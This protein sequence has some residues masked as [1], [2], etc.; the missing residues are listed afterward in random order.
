[1]VQL[2]DT[3]DK[4]Q[5]LLSIEN[6]SK[7]FSKNLKRSM[8]YGFK[9]MIF[10]DKNSSHL[11]KSEFWA[12][13]NINLQL[14]R[15]EI[16]GLLGKNGAGK[17]TLIRLITDTFPVTEG[18]IVRRGRITTIYEKNRSFNKFYSGRDNIKVKCALFGMTKKEIKEKMPE[19]V[20]FSEIEPFVD[21]PFGTYSSGMR[22][23]V[24]V[25]IALLANPDILI[26]DEG[27]ALSDV[28][29]RE[30]CYAR[31]KEISKKCGIIQISHNM[32]QIEKLANRIAIMRNGEIKYDST[33]FEEGIETYYSFKEN[34]DR[35]NKK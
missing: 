1:M 12:L 20:E 31:I 34:Y 16:L 10:E 15:G 19:I 18:K 25:A 7:K 3:Y 4:D 24:N 2:E 6:V 26:I 11:R 27:L 28:F 17:T 8:M 21:A 14:K 29:F 23:K 33:N 35:K 5:N 30:K 13:K 32:E 22:A 9:D